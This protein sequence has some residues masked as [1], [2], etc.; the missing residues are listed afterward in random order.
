MGNIPIVCKEIDHRLGKT[1]SSKGRETSLGC[2]AEFQRFEDAK[3]AAPG[4]ALS[5]LSRLV[6]M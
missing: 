1:P 6:K 5:Q 2:F 4:R 3:G